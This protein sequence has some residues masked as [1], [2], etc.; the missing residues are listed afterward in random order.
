MTIDDEEHD[1]FNEPKQRSRRSSALM[2][3]DFFWDCV[4]EDAPFGSDE[5]WEAYYSFRDWRSEN[6]KAKVSEFF[7]AVMYERSAE[8]NE[9]LT[10]DDA[11]I[12]SVKSPKKAFLGKEYDPGVLDVSVIAICLGQL[13]DEGK[14]DS[15][16]KPFARV[17]ISR[18]SHKAFRPSKH[19]LK[20]LQACAR[21]I[22][23]A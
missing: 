13:I 19:R 22:Q 16:I 3:E 10:T 8:Y 5:G 21:V 1:P 12:Q 14:I 4:D 20:I 17:A 2:K 7:D 23:E 11:I 6:P 18:Q 9:M 15:S